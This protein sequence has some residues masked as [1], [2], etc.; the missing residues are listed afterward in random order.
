MLWLSRVL[1]FYFNARRI[2]PGPR[3]LDSAQAPKAKR[4][5]RLLLLLLVAVWLYRRMRLARL[6]QQTSAS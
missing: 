6:A 4:R 2:E 1:I 3:K 5:R